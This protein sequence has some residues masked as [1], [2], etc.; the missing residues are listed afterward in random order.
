MAEEDA[1][2]PMANLTV[3][4]NVNRSAGASMAE[5]AASSSR[6]LAPA[7]PKDPPVINDSSAEEGV[8]ASDDENKVW[9]TGD[10][11]PENPHNW[12]VWRKY[13]NSAL[14]SLLTLITPLASNVFAP[15][16]PDLMVYFKSSNTELASFVVSVYV[17]GFACGPLV[18]APL[19]ELYGRLPVY[20]VCNIIFVIFT[21]GC[22]IAPTLDALIVFRFFAG[23]FGACPLTNGGGSIADMFH[24]E[25]RA[26]VMAAFSIG[27]LL[28][29]IIGPA[30]G[31]V[32]AQNKGW[33]WVFWLVAIMGAAISVAMVLVM[34]ESYAPVILE[35][36]TK[37][38]R[39]ETGNEQL[40]SKL[41]E[42]LTSRQLFTL[43]IVRPVKL[44]VFSPICTVFA[45][46]IMMVYGYQYLLCTTIAYVFKETYGFSS[47]E[48]GLVF[49]S[50]GVGCFLGMI[51]FGV[52]S[53]VAMK[54][55]KEQDSEGGL[56]PEV[57][58]RL[59]PAGAIIY[60][61]GFFIYGWT[62][63]FQTHWL[64]P[65]AGLFLIGIGNI[66]SMMAV[67]VYLVD[68]YER[69]AASAL[70]AN[71]VMRSIAGA[72]LPLCSLK[73]YSHLGLGWGNSLLGFISIALIPIPLYIQR[74]G[75]KLRK[76]FDT[77]TL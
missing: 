38:L 46:Y 44:L 3:D 70:A 65:I 21:A 75:E 34:R 60:P 25:E 4:G 41:D 72:V 42:G 56:K 22:A 54:R 32:L 30:A 1:P 14:I 23:C 45:V 6:T 28:G 39:K 61:L 53:S 8:E 52:D 13:S 66:L 51:W 62:A 59:L 73:M 36:R 20:H 68:A 69:Y 49:L 18:F 40:R 37:K 58:L 71:T 48:S 26:A 15:A 7:N 2:I 77:S 57:R 11:D 10:D 67:S 9:W 19:S 47:S 74:Y 29:P 35:R 16:I 24:P 76:K 12:P 17:L 50:A 63:H 31:G 64:G 5:T 33:R 55:I 27:P 43:S